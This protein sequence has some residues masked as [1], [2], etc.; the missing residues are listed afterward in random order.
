[1]AGACKQ[2][3]HLE[4]FLHLERKDDDDGVHAF[5]CS[6]RIPI[7]LRGDEQ[8]WDDLQQRGGPHGELDSDGKTDGSSHMWNAVKFEGEW[9]MVDCTWGDKKSGPNHKYLNFGLDRAKKLYD[10]SK[11]ENPMT[12]AKKTVRK[13]SH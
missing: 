4:Q 1:M 7:S 13:Y 5:G 3:R 11:K 2:Q 9:Y 6:E 8:L 10:W 12:F